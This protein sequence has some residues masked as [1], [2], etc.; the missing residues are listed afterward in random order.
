MGYGQLAA[1]M[2]YVFNCNFVFARFLG[3]AVGVAGCMVTVRGMG[4]QVRG[5]KVVSV[6]V[7]CGAV[8]F[9]AR[10]EVLSE[11]CAALVDGDCVADGSG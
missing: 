1:S 10:D 6:F 7:L 5:R 2:L 9:G 11:F 4:P 3:V 8:R